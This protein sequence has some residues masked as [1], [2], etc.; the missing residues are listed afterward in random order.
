MLLPDKAHVFWIPVAISAI[1]TITLYVAGQGLA[2]A[3]DPRN[4]R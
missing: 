4:H 1:V 3:S 2:D